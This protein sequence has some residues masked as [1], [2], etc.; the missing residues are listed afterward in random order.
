MGYHKNPVLQEPEASNLG[1][2]VFGGITQRLAARLLQQLLRAPT[3][4]NK[5]QPPWALAHDQRAKPTWEPVQSFITNGPKA[6][7][8]QL[9][10]KAAEA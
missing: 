2:R 10:P 8:S 9:S 3:T 4:K 5:Q 1:R 7:F 6:N